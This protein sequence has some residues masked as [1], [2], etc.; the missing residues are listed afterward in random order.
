MNASLPQ[1]VKGIVESPMQE[2]SPSSAK[3]EAS[4]WSDIEVWRG[5]IVVWEREDWQTLIHNVCPALYVVESAGSGEVA[6]A[7]PSRPYPRRH[8]HGGDCV[9]DNR[10]LGKV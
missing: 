4:V 2:P 3:Y 6:R 1:G 10:S 7:Y 8:S 5:E 9:L